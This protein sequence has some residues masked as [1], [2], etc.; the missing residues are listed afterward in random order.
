MSGDPWQDYL[1][2]AR[3]LDAVRRAAAGAAAEQD[4]GVHSALAELAGVR[5]RLVPQ[6]SRLRA[7]GVAEADLV[8]SEPEVAAAGQ[9]MA[10][11]PQAV[12]A[13]LRAARA[14]ADAADA[15]T[16]LPGA[17]PLPWPRTLLY[18][19]LALAVLCVLSLLCLGGFWLVR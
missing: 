3:G 15:A 4:R 5:A 2:A 18:G 8:P 7:L 16:R 12:L 1:A 11:G 13:A 6:Q 9:A 10:G 19:A 17:G 14:T